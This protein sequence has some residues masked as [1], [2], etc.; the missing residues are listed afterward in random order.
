MG[1]KPDMCIRLVSGGGKQLKFGACAAASYYDGSTDRKY[2]YESTIK[3][4]KMLK[5][6]LFDLCEYVD[7]DVQKTKQIEVEGCMQSGLVIDE[8]LAIIHPKD[9]VVVMNQI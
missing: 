2:H 9:T 3:L 6:V 5:D 4:P 1:S 7:W 8:L